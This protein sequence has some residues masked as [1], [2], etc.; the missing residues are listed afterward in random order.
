MDIT[1]QIVHTTLSKGRA[2]KTLKLFCA[3]P[4]VTIRTTACW[5]TRVVYSSIVCFNFLFKTN[6]YLIKYN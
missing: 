6:K 4:G 1:T 2:P 3:L 5:P